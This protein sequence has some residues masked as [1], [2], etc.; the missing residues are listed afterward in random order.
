MAK[1]PLH[2]LWKQLVTMDIC[3][4][5]KMHAHI[6]GTHIC[7]CALPVPAQMH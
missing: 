3:T 1:L 2:M 5:T 6:Y 4:A 7:P